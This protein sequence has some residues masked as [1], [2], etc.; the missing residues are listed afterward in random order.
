MQKATRKSSIRMTS[1][2]YKQN[3]KRKLSE[4]LKRNQHHQPSFTAG[5]IKKYSD[6]AF[7]QAEHV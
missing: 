3:W 1:S 2:K 4:S 5:I 7:K 6:D